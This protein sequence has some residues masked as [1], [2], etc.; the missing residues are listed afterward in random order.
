MHTHIPSKKEIKDVWV[1]TPLVGEKLW[2]FLDE[3]FVNRPHEALEDR[4]LYEILPEPDGEKRARA[5]LQNYP[6]RPGK[7]VDDVLADARIQAGPFKYESAY[8]ASGGL[9]NILLPRPE[10]A[11]DEVW[12]NLVQKYVKQVSF[13]SEDEKERRLKELGVL[14]NYTPNDLFSMLTPAQVWAGAGLRESDLLTRFFEEITYRFSKKIKSPGEAILRSLLYL[15]SWQTVPLADYRFKTAF[16]VIQAEREDIR[17]KKEALAGYHR[18]V[19]TF[20]IL[21]EMDAVAA[22]LLD[23][24]SALYEAEFVEDCLR[25]WIQVKNF[26]K[27]EHPEAAAATMAFSV[28]KK[29]GW[30]SPVEHFA[31]IFGTEPEVVAKVQEKINVRKKSEA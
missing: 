18:P 31:T 2:Q 4:A 13:T 21:N 15:R 9:L 1:P 12:Q 11:V 17:L 19:L 7:T 22:L 16:Q 20:H 24:L 29:L 30:D 8:E 25:L 28:S 23:V 26:L 10:A 14:W 5:F 27:G 3:S 6:P